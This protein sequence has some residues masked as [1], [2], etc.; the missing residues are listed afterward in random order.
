MQEIESER[1][2]CPA[3]PK[4]V[5]A[6]GIAP[7]ASFLGRPH[8][9]AEQCVV[10][11][12]VALGASTRGTPKHPSCDHEQLCRCPATAPGRAAP[13]STTSP[14]ST[15]FHQQKKSTMASTVH[16][17]PRRH[18][19]EDSCSVVTHGVSNASF[20]LCQCCFSAAQC[21][22]RDCTTTLHASFS[23]KPNKKRSALWVPST[24]GVRR[25]LRGDPSPAL[26]P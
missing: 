3:R 26:S 6:V 1:N 19:Q 2:L 16:M 15:L 24:S 10:P 4:K 7:P 14:E 25:H 8:F 12:P 23:T 22:N 21:W 9:K 13:M 17:P 18:P 20:S 11:S 5:T